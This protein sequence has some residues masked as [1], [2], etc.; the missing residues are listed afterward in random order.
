MQTL[1]CACPGST[2]AARHV[3][4]CSLK[5]A[6]ARMGCCPPTI[7]SVGCATPVR[8]LVIPALACRNAAHWCAVD[9][10]VERRCAAE[11]GQG[12]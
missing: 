6:A 10:S 3:C 5:I 12:S 1:A 7:R 2:G 9:G 8:Y 4:S 11:M